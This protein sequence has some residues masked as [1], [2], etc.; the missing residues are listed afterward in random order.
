MKHVTT[1]LFVLLLLSTSL[2]HAQEIHLHFPHFA[3]HQYE[4]KIFQGEK[5]IIVQSDQIPP[6]GRVT[7]AM[8]E[9]YQEYL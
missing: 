8:P 4:W 5:Q 9:A 2:L 3:G 7:L 6:D 1:T